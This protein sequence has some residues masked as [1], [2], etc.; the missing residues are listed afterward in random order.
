METIKLTTKRGFELEF[1]HFTILTGEN[2]V[3]KTD[4]IRKFKKENGDKVKC[5]TYDQTHDPKNLGEILDYDLHNAS[6]FDPSFTFIFIHPEN[7]LCGELQ[8][9]VGRKIGQLA[10]AG[11]RVIVETHSEHVF[12]GITITSIKESLK[13]PYDEIVTYHFTYE[14]TIRNYCFQKITMDKDRNLSDLP[15]NFLAQ[16]M[17]KDLSEIIDLLNARNDAVKN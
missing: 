16:Q 9:E 2:G 5:I 8:S 6:K 11:F 1:G 7:N 12:N 15:T 17:R 10:A 14:P 4:I 3:G 13:L